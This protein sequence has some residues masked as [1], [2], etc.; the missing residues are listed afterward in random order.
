VNRC[1]RGTRLPAS[2]GWERMRSLR[3]SRRRLSRRRTMVCRWSRTVGPVRSDHLVGCAPRDRDRPRMDDHLDR[4]RL[5]DSLGRIPRSISVW[6]DPRRGHRPHHR[7]LRTLGSR[8]RRSP[9]DDSAWSMVPDC[10]SNGP[11]PH[12]CPDR[13]AGLS[14]AHRQAP[15]RRGPRRRVREGAPVTPP[16]WSHATRPPWLQGTSPG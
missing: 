7:A 1:R 2:V 14:L 16:S 3:R 12:I 4:C 8:P 15:R 9:L 5:T 6:T 11:T 13:S 10:G